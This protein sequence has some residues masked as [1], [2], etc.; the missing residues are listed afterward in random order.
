MKKLFLTG[1]TSLLGVALL[2]RIPS[3]WKIILAQHKHRNIFPE[4]KNV[5][6]VILDV[7]DQTRI[8]TLIERFEPD[9]ILHAA[10]LSN[11]DFCQKHQKETWLVNV[12]GTRNIVKACEQSRIPLLY[13]SSNAVFDGAKDLYGE[14]DKPNPVNFYGKT[15]YEGEKI[16]QKSSLPWIIVRLITMYGW[17]PSGTRQ[18]PVTWTLEKLQNG[19]KLRI[20]ND[21][22]LNPLYNHDAA[23]ALWIIIEKGRNKN[24]YHAAGSEV[25]NRYQWALETAKV[26]GFDPSLISPVSSSFFNRKI[27]PRPP[28]TIYSIKK[29]KRELGIRPKGIKEGLK[30]MEDEKR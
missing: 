13:I 27:A 8:S 5:E 18:N 16:V 17:P 2:A 4:S 3:D 14:K 10:A 26:F 23:D 7:T 11:V 29:I 12:K 22:R 30:A 24:I 28:Q 19:E 20:V 21:V 15:K 1:G 6:P 25:V 9:L